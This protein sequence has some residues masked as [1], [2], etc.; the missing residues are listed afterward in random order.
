MKFAVH[1]LVPS[2]SNLLNNLV[3]HIHG[4]FHLTHETQGG[5]AIDQISQRQ[6]RSQD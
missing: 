1:S 2:S 4:D 5:W 6:Q 3:D